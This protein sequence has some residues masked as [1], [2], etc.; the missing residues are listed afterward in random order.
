MNGVKVGNGCFEG[1]NKWISVASFCCYHVDNKDD[2]MI[3]CYEN[4]H[5]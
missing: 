2:D 1:D 4:F 3:R 5:F